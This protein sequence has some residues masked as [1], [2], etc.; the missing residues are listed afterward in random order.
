MFFFA[1]AHVIFATS[2]S[3]MAVTNKL[4]GK[5][6]WVFLGQTPYN[7]SSRDNDDLPISSHFYLWQSMVQTLYSRKLDG[8]ILQ[9]RPS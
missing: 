5:A 1:M 3:L 6:I 4:N 9:A 7:D 8:L 2:L